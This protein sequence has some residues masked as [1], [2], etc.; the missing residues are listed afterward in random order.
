MTCPSAR[1]KQSAE[2]ES[3]QEK[4]VHVSTLAAVW[5]LSLGC[6][7]WPHL[8]CL[9]VFLLVFF[10]QSISREKDLLLMT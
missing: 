4:L 5:F 1:G 9:L 10:S 8:V 6:V 3:V 2:M 7:Y